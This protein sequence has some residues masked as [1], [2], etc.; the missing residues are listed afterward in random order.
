MKYL[1]MFSVLVCLSVYCLGAPHWGDVF[2]LGQPD[3]SSVSVLVWGDEFYQRVES[4]DGYTL[5]RDMS[6]G[7]ICYAELSADERE[8]VSTGV[9]YDPDEVDSAVTLSGRVRGKKV[10]KGL[11]LKKS[12]V[13]EKAERRKKEIHG[14]SYLPSYESGVDDGSI[15]FAAGEGFFAPLTGS[16]IGLTILVDFPDVPGSIARQDVH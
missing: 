1:C 8:F 10:K 15:G 4:F 11:R 13:R 2:E 9:V 5:I 3:G 14:E 12:A 16:V 6:T 7:W